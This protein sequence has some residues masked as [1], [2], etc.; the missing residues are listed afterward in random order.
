METTEK[1]QRG[2]AHHRS[3]S[4]PVF[5]L[6]RAIEKTKAI[7]DQ[8]RRAATSADVIASHL[9]YSAAKGPG[10]RAVSA[11]KQYGLI[12]EVSGKYRIS[13]LGYTLVHFDR[14]SEEWQRAID[15]AAKR[16]ALFRELFEEHQNGLPSDAALRN[17]LLKRGFNPA[18]VPEVIAIARGTLSL[19]S[20]DGVVHNGAGEEPTMQA[21]A[22]EATRSQ[23][24]PGV[25]TS[26]PSSTK[27]MEISL[28][29]GT[30]D[31]EIVFAT[32]KFSAGIKRNLV[33]SLRS[34]LEAMEKTL[35]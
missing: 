35:P 19:A 22:T 21:P 11:L 12:E 6:G 8:D 1:E 13:D 7:Y 29:V 3:P 33:V 4:Y 5:D 24:Q 9:G 2:S 15:D 26:T 17:E 23:T 27:M 25:R 16:P 30:E 10:G 28:P 20:Q 14:D 18:A 32:V 34:L 31:G